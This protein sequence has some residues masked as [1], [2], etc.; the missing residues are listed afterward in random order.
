MYNWNENLTESQIH[1]NANLIIFGAAAASALI[2]FFIFHPDIQKIGQESPVL[3]NIM[4]A[5]SFAIGFVYGMKI[6][7]K[8][9]NPAEIRSPLKRGLIKILLFFFIIGGL[10]S[11]VNFALSGG[12]LMPNTS[13]LEDGL[14]PWINDLVTTNGG[15]TFLIVSSITLMGSATRRIVGLGGKLN[16]MFTFIGTFIFFSMIA[17]SL[18]QGDPSNSEVYLYTFYQS[19]IIG[20]ALFQMNRLTS[21]LNRWED[22][23]NGYY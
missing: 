8:I 10:F 2:L 12:G 3:I 22:F 21:N 17:L 14:I 6:T 23:A 13:L 7:E 11:S 16:S 1:R 18:T 20:G 4:F 5:P 19:G 15:A 9:V